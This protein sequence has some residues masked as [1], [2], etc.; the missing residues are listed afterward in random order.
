MASEYPPR[1]YT[2]SNM[3][4]VVFLEAKLNVIATVRITDHGRAN[5]GFADSLELRSAINEFFSGASLPTKTYGGRLMAMNS[6]CRS[7]RIQWLRAK[8]GSVSP[9]AMT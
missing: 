7:L 8:Q 5:F 6:R 2:L 4:L 1:E 9:P 3:V